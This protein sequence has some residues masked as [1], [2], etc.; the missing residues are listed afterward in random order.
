MK[1]FEKDLQDITKPDIQVP[2][3]QQNLRR[4]LL[5]SAAESHSNPSRFMFGFAT[6]SAGLFGALL[7]LFV[8]QPDVPKQLHNMIVGDMASVPTEP[9]PRSAHVP[10]RGAIPVANDP[11]LADKRL[12][13]DA[14]RAFLNDWLRKESP[15]GIS[16]L[17]TVA[18]EG[19]IS[20]RRYLDET[21]NEV[22]VYTNLNKEDIY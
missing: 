15:K 1:E 5:T 10:Q 12:S 4:K 13:Q 9:A 8:A 6:F 2:I 14:D 21:G 18:G 16:R 19:V 17:K 3:F 20:F 7:I 11:L 22:I